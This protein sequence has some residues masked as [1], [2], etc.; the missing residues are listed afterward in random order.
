MALERH[1]I[2]A[3]AALVF[4]L[5]LAHAEVSQLRITKQPGALFTPMI[6][7]EQNKLIEKHAAAA[8]LGNDFKVEWLTLSSGGAATDGLL[9]GSVDIVTSGTTNMLLLW[10]KTNGDVK[11]IAG[12]SGLPFK[13]VT[14]NPNIKTIKDYGPGDRIALPTVRVS[15]QAMTLGIALQK[16]YG[17]DKANE[18]LL[19]NQVQMGHPDATAA[20]LNPVHEVTSHFS[21]SPF[22][23]MLLSRPGYHVVLE[24][25]DALG[26]GAH[27]ALSFATTKFYEANP[28]LM[29]AYLAAVDE[30]TAMV[31]NDPQTTAEKYLS[32]TKEK[33]TV[34]DMVVLLKQP[35][36]IFQAHPVRTMVY[37]TYMYKAGFIK[38]EPKSWKDYFF[39][40]IHDREGS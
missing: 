30:A 20:M 12:I 10:G 25:R 28:K 26:G 13:L 11:T 29:R 18:K 21:A 5:S 6:L 8:G 1:C 34:D 19:A 9:A 14:R 24:S 32:V 4:P 31:R 27:I 22:Q 15:I 40:M 38:L 37:A 35:E 33:L 17:D 39:P 23:E 3:V 2:A 7:M 36:A 16:A